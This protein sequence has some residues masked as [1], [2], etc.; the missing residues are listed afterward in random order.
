MV[1]LSF[2]QKQRSPEQQLAMPCFWFL[3]C[4]G[5]CLCA[6]T[7]FCPSAPTSFF[8]PCAQ[9]NFCPTQ[10]FYRKIWTAKSKKKKKERVQL[11]FSTEYYTGPEITQK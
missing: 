6:P 4:Y 8:C 7:S 1:L 10:D 2:Y 5:C 9:K 11:K 3:P